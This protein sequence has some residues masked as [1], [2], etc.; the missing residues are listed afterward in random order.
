M[1]HM[2]TGWQDAACY[3]TIIMRFVLSWVCI[4]KFHTA[5]CSFSCEPVL[6]PHATEY[7]YEHVLQY[8][9]IQQLAMHHS[10]GS[11]SRQQNLPAL[12]TT[13]K[14]C[15]PAVKYVLTVHLGLYTGSWG[16]QWHP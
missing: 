2:H 6:T 5:W 1:Y 10:R 8:S 13:F 4:V 11:S 12:R 14:R 15:S 3:C 16:L 7:C 9:S